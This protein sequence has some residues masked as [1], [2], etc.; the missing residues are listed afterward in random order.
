MRRALLATALLLACA[1]ARRPAPGDAGVTFPPDA[2]ARS[3][4]DAELAGKNDEELLA[5]GT[6]A[7]G[8][9][10]PDD[11]ARAAA[12]FAALADRYPRSPHV[13]RALLGA[14]AAYARQGEW[15][16]ALERFRALEARGGPESLEGAFRAAEAHYRLDDL[17]DARATLERLLARPELPAAARVRALAERGVVELEAGKPEQAE[18]TLREALAAYAAASAT[19]RLAPG[20]AAQALF[21]LG[22]LRRAALL[23]APLDPARADAGALAA[24]LERK[25]ALLLA[26]QEEYLAAIRLGDERWAVAAGY[27]VGE[28]YDALREQVLEAPLPPGLDDA[29]AASY[30]AELRRQVRVLAAKAMTAYE[31]TLELARR[32]GVEDVRFLADA[33]SSLDRLRATLAAE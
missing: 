29:Q 7:A 3:A 21:Y 25:S 8:A 18:A 15:R 11:D 30:R 14:G 13:P 12:A 26:A 5:I 2:P 23:A 6:A 1:T 28:L 17:P 24:E 16:L 27:R 4:L 20:S 32:A 10:G 9:A 33:A 22:E 31:E 19:E